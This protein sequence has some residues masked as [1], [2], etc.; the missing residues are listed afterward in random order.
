MGVCVG[1]GVSPLRRLLNAL[2]IK[3]P[4]SLEES[5]TTRLPKD[6][7]DSEGMNSQQRHCE[8]IT[9]HIG[10]GGDDDDDCGF[11]TCSSLLIYVMTVP[12]GD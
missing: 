8:N 9:S 4:G 2:K 7:H 3:A 11:N 10:G 12:S 5:G 1:C 6:R